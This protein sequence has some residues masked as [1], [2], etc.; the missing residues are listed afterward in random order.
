MRRIFILILTVLALELFAQTEKPDTNRIYKA[1][2]YLASDS[3]KGRKPGM[4]GCRLAAEF[5]RDGFKAAGLQLMANN[6]FQDFK[7]VSEVSLGKNCKFKI[8]ANDAVLEKDF[9][10]AS[11]SGNGQLKASV[12]F[13]GYGFAINE[14]SLQ[15][16]DY[17]D[18]DVNGKWVMAFRADP[19]IDSMNSRFLSYADDRHKALVASNNGAKGLILITGK[20]LSKKDKL[21]KLKYTQ[22]ESVTSIPVIYI[23]RS[24]ADNILSDSEKKIS[25]LEKQLNQK[26][27][28]LSFEVNKQ[29]SAGVDLAFQK[30]TTQNVVAMLEGT[31]KA[32]TGK[33]ILVGAHYDHLGI[34]G[35]NSGSRMPDTIAVHNGADDNASGVAGIMELAYL[36]GKSKQKMK[37]SVIF[38]AFTAEEMGLVGSKYFVNNPLID[39]KNIEL[40]INFDMIGR[41]NKEAD[42]TV[43]G[44]GTS[45]EGTDLLNS[46]NTN[47]NF[48]LTFV[49]SGFGPSDHSSFY[50]NDIPV[51][52]FYSGSHDDYHTPNDDTEFINETGMAKIIG[53]SCDLIKKV[54][55]RDM[56][57]TFQ[58]TEEPEATKS[59]R[60]RF[61][62]TLGIIPDFASVEKRGLRID[63]VKKGRPASMAGLKKGDIIIE[64]DNHKIGNIYDYMFRLG[65]YDTGD[66]A[67]VKII[68]GNKEKVFIVEF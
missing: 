60:A 20:S 37:R 56:A 53:F 19:E 17:K 24:V 27:K 4:P 63:G 38:V 31:D 30:K 68:R 2:D 47:Y 18:M 49:S 62:V 50:S 13:A 33:Y 40:M 16:N 5:I 57:L 22:N 26:R 44:T 11:F 23:T 10:P 45:K 67:N 64:M 42:L 32:F 36:F 61:K 12:V 29:I 6:G 52:F 65:K 9:M 41:L 59:G 35:P 14:D 51:L 15:W 39:L 3:L 25:G 8:A 55:N 46:I 54:A 48:N 28:P 34:G 66:R 1:I 58:E 43:Y 7:I 21:P